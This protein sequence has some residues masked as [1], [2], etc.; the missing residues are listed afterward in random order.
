MNPT[1]RYSKISYFV[2]HPLTELIGYL[3]NH[4]GFSDDTIF[5]IVSTCVFSQLQA[6]QA[7]GVEHVHNKH[8]VSYMGFDILLDELGSA[9]DSPFSE[10]IPGYESDESVVDILSTVFI[11]LPNDLIYFQ[12]MLEY[13]IEQI[14]IRVKDDDLLVGV[15]NA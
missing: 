7:C 1:T 5:E 15:E 14:V 10:I 12:C 3:R 2:R 13:R 6:M 9:P 8:M 11:N 4:Y